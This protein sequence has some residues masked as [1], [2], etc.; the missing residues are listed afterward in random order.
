MRNK[1]AVTTRYRFISRGQHDID[2]FDTS[3]RG[4]FVSKAL[5]PLR[6]SHLW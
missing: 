3:E 1:T 4:L 2:P 5:Q 6:S